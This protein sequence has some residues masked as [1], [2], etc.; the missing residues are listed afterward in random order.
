MERR[1]FA[2]D[3][4]T[5]VRGA[6]RVEPGRASR[7]AELA[8]R[9]ELVLGTCRIDPARRRVAGPGGSVAVEPRVMQVLVTLAEAGGQVVG[10]DQLNAICW[11]GQVVGD[12][13]LNRA[14]GE[15]R[16]AL[17]TV[18]ADAAIETIP[19]IGYRL[20]APAAAPAADPPAATPPP[21]R[22][23]RLLLGGA[24][25]G[26]A[27][28]GLWLWRRPPPRDPRVAALL[29]RARQAL[30]DQYPQA[31]EQ[32][33]GFLA[34][35]LA[36]APD[37]AEAWGLRAIAERNMAEYAPVEQID[38]ATARCQQ[39]ARRALLL[40]PHQPEAE[41]ALATLPPIF[42]DW[43]AAERRLRPVLA[44]HPDQTDALAAMAVLMISVGRIE[45]GARHNRRAA[46]LEPLSPIFQYRR[47]YHQ[48]FLGDLAA[49]D[50]TIDRAMQLWPRHPAIWYAR[51]H[52]FGLTGR[53]AAARAMLETPAAAAMMGPGAAVW[54]ATMRALEDRS[55]AR[56]AA[57][58]E[59]N[60][61]AARHGNAVN[62]ILLLSAL[63]ALDEMF[64]VADA[65]LLFR[66]PLLAPADPAAPGHSVN[67]Q[68]FKKTM[69]LFNP[70]L[71]AAR[72]DPRFGR[73]C[74]EIGLAGYW[75]VAGVRPD[76]PIASA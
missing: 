1:S 48:W 15:A 44:R 5:A 50:R 18:D 36:L 65:Y 39:S 21:D 20:A 55:P 31:D 41:A 72:A 56:R 2:D 19:K 60:L 53:P 26:V 9:A 46:T 43:R 57:A 54:R 76:L 75:R 74:R 10:R 67:D 70:A 73:L 62:A 58:I 40:Q 68:R 13:A 32:G 38:A 47:A 25:A 42:G 7:P 45:D 66:G 37:D 69:M 27:A 22:T 61:A 63:G 34:Q 17:R 59:A 49:G 12:D 71:A 51:M 30:R 24:L 4:A 64:A 14:V 23:R 16:R 33:A 52:M 3:D 11:N 8:A 35:A 6:L 29:E 28:G